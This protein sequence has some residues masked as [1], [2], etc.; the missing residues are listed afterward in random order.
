MESQVIS[1]I[2]ILTGVLKYFYVCHQPIM[3]KFKIKVEI[4]LHNK[5]KKCYVLALTTVTDGYH[6]R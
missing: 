2:N 5:K 3:V 4:N 6:H 1:Y